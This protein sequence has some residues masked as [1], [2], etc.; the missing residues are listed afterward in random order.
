MSIAQKV[1]L[2]VHGISLPSHF[3]VKVETED[4][5]K[6]V[7]FGSNNQLAHV[8][9]TAQLTYSSPGHAVNTWNLLLQS[10]MIQ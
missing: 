3:L 7:A 6:L 1:G 8:C 4:G 10:T 9:K 2:Q 5:G